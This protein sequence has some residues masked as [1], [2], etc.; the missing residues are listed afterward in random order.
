LR[1]SYSKA[2]VKEEKSSGVVGEKGK[3][4][5]DVV[6]LLERQTKVGYF[7]CEKGSNCC[8]RERYLE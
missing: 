5:D 4:E 6:G 7:V 8:R 1:I 2:G 3:C